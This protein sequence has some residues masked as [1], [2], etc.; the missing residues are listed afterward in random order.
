MTHCCCIISPIKVDSIS[1]KLD[2]LGSTR[3]FTLL[4]QLLEM[5]ILVFSYTMRVL[6]S[7]AGAFALQYRAN[8]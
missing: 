1:R 6:V 8:F 7:Y 3:L 5:K 2:E 4:L